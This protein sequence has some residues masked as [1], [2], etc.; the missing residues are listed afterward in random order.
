MW[1]FSSSLLISTIPISIGGWGFREGIFIISMKSLGID[2]ETAIIISLIYASQFSL[3]GLVGGTLWS[4]RFV[5][6]N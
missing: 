5:K 3:I 2:S 1:L 4:S 6:R